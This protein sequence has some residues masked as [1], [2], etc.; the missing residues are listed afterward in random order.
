MN[1]ITSVWDKLTRAVKALVPN[2]LDD[3]VAHVT[4][5]TAVDDRRSRWRGGHGDLR[6]RGHREGRQ[7][8]GG[9]GS[10]SAGELVGGNKRSDL[11]VLPKWIYGAVSLL[12]LRRRPRNGRL[13]SSPR[14]RAH[15]RLSLK[16][17]SSADP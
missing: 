8:C 11:R 5:D 2:A 12:L 16:G 3:I 9:N 1:L 13:P 17:A 6:H 14:S 10:R 4:D 7:W 15:G